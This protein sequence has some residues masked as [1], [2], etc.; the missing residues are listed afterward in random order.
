[1]VACTLDYYWPTHVIASLILLVGGLV[2][3]LPVRYVCRL[4]S[5]M[6]SDRLRGG[7][8][9]SGAVDRCHKHLLNVQEAADVILSGDSLVSK[10]FVSFTFI[11]RNITIRG[12]PGGVLICRHP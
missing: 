4:S 9:D 5:M 7:G 11:I 12:D 6:R 8:R 3:M 1:M 10:V 2:I